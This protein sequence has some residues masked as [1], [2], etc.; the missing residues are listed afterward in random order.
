MI[1]TIRYL[2]A[3]LV[4]LTLESVAPGDVVKYLRCA[5]IELQNRNF[6]T[7]ERGIYR[8]TNAN[9]SGWE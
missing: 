5:K 2:G 6:R 1:G 4:S 8:V 3:A 7:L 9:A